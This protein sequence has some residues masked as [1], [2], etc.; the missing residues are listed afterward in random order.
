VPSEYAVLEDPENVELA[1][2]V[3]E[4]ELTRLAASDVE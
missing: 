2:D 3:A 1:D 4:C